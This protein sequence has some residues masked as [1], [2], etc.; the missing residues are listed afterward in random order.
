[1]GDFAMR[2][3]Y[4][5]G[6]PARGPSPLPRIRQRWTVLKS[7][8]AMKKAQ[9]NFERRTMRRLVEIQDGDPEVVKIWLAYL[10]K[11]AFYGV[12]MK[13][14]LWEWE[15]L[16]ASLPFHYDSSSFLFSFAG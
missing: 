16:G 11:Y 5:L 6:L 15:G 12:G 1:M 4:Y 13:A 3:A 8:F 2:A 9:E 10:R 7:P 14:N